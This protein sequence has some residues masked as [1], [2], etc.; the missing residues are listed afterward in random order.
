M[1]GKTLREALLALATVVRVTDF[2]DETETALELMNKFPFQGMFGG[3]TIDG[4]GRVV[5]RTRAALTTD[6]GEFEQALWE[7]VVRGADLSYQVRTQTGIIP[8][9]NQINFEHSFLLEDLVDLVVD[10]PF[11]PRGHEELFARGFLAAS[12]G[13]SQRAYPFSCRSLKIRFVTCLRSPGMNSRRET[14]TGYRT[15]FRWAGC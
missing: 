7:R 9:I 10:N 5:G 13:V 12:G 2:E 1:A 8:A 15:S 3:M 4:S 14:A 6:P 11:V